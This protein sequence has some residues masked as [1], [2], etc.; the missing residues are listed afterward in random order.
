M[1]AVS[2]NRALDLI[3]RTPDAALTFIEKLDRSEWSITPLSSTAPSFLCSFA[4]TSADASEFLEHVL[5]NAP[6][7][8]D[9]E[10]KEWKTALFLSFKDAGNRG[11]REENFLVLWNACESFLTEEDRKELMLLTLTKGGTSW[12]KAVERI[13]TTS[14]CDWNTPVPDLLF[15]DGKPEVYMSSQKFKRGEARFLQLARTK[16]AI[17]ALV[18]A[19]VQVDQ[20]VNGKTLRQ[21][22][23]DRSVDT[24]DGADQRKAALS[25]MER[26]VP[27]EWNQATAW[28]AVVSSRQAADIDRVLVATKKDWPTWRGPMGETLAHHIAM[29][30]PEQM[31]K[32]F[33]RGEAPEDLASQVDRNG[34]DVRAWWVAGMGRENSTLTSTHCTLEKLPQ[35]ARPQNN[36]EAALLSLEAFLAAFNPDFSTYGAEIQGRYQKKDFFSS[37]KNHPSELGVHAKPMPEEKDGKENRY[38]RYKDTTERER[39][40]ASHKVSR[41]KLALELIGSNLWNGAPAPEGRRALLAGA[42]AM[43]MRANTTD[44]RRGYSHSAI[45]QEYWNTWADA[46]IRLP[47]DRLSEKEEGYVG[48]Y[49]AW[50]AIKESINAKSLKCEGREWNRAIDSG[51]NPH[52]LFE[53]MSPESQKELLALQWEERAIAP[54]ERKKLQERAMQRMAGA[55]E[56]PLSF[57]AL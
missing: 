44:F 2:V 36:D 23:I 28:E 1:P 7:T 15:K 4:Q 53:L 6:P 34:L 31:A 54:W 48:E 9:Q 18:K 49:L 12:N 46:L 42:V 38:G 33:K 20:A 37:M 3:A 51:I 11:A 19:G 56:K 14:Q 16:D 50:H 29:Y 8:T 32:V 13:T 21:K 22:M 40:Y 47:A 35:F 27:R 25:W 57:D 10:K 24:F 55:D 26:E 52:E 45:K 30:A 39:D 17:V 5:K 41:D 43:C